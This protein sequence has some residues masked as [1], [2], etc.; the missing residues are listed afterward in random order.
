MNM[1]CPTPKISGVTTSPGAVGGRPG[2]RP[3][4]EP[5]DELRELR[6]QIEPLRQKFADYVEANTVSPNR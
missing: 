6:E 3:M 2:I 5:N 1:F 4:T